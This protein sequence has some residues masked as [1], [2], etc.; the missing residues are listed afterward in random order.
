[1]VNNVGTAVNLLSSTFGF[2]RLFFRFNILNATLKHLKLY[3]WR[4]LKENF[5]QIQ[6]SK[7][8]ITSYLSIYQVTKN[9]LLKSNMKQSINFLAHTPY[10]IKHLLGAIWQIKICKCKILSGLNLHY[11]KKSKQL[12]IISVHSRVN[13]L[14]KGWIDRIFYICKL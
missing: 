10:L 2:T 6:N 7:R 5:R 11:Y 13:T 4:R 12:F 9:K 8:N 14:F 1:M 3:S